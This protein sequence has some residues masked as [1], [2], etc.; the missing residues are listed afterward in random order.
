MSSS[1]SLSPFVCFIALVIER[2]TYQDRRPYVGCASITFYRLPETETLLLR[3][4]A[5]SL[6][7]EAPAEAHESGGI[8]DEAEEEGHNAKRKCSGS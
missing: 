6:T 2:K 1:Q 7:T 8:Q 5:V 3:P 4:V